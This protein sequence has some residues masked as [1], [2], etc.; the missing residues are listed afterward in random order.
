MERIKKLEGIYEKYDYS[1]TDSGRVIN[2]KTGREISGWKHRQGYIRVALSNVDGIME[3]FKHR[4]VAYHFCDNFC[5]LKVVNH[6]DGNKENNEYSNLEWVTSSENNFHAYDSGLK[7]GRIIVYCPEIDCYFRS[8]ADAERLTGIPNQNI[9]KVANGHRKFAGR[10]V[11]TGEDLRW[12][13][14]EGE[15]TSSFYP[16][17]E[18]QIQKCLKICSRK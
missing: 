18:E 3:V 13:K 9:S 14:I 4:L 16:Y 7:K 5:E 10:N 17:T 12:I 2:N 8:M 15:D 11:E 6:K 1:I